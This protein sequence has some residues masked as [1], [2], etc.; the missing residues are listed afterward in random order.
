M[1]H[2]IL[3][4][5]LKRFFGSTQTPPKEWQEFLQAISDTY[6]HYDEDRVLIERSLDISSREHTEYVEALKRQTEV[7]ESLAD[8]TPDIIARFDRNLRHVYV[9]HQVEL[10]TN[11]KVNDF[12]GK[13]NTDLGQ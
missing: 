11:L 6:V 7:F 1:L 13:T 12:I 9:N 10:V 8:N 2:K 5:Q 3:E 4:R